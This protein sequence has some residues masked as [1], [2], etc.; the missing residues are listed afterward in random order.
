MKKIIEE[1]LVMIFVIVL[2]LANLGCTS[3]SNTP[4]GVIRS[5][6]TYLDK[7]EYEKAAS[8]QVYSNTG[9]PLSEEHIKRYV[10]VHQGLYGK[11]GEYLKIKNFKITR[12][13]KL[14]EY[15]LEKCNAERGYKI[16][17]EGEF[18]LGG[19]IE[20]EVRSGTVIY[21]NRKWWLMSGYEE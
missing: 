18:N 13:E 1:L 17:V 11:N 21:K 12:K 15:S 5:Y 9:N 14:S 6:Y 7:G 8:M 10:L 16:W 2:V 19:R 20:S 4:E 3:S